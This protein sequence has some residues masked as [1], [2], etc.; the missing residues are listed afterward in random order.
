LTN[1]TCE[2]SGNILLTVTGGTAP[3]RYLWS[4]GDTTNSPAILV[5]DFYDV[6]ITDD[7]GC[8]TI[9]TELP[10]N[11]ECN[12]CIPPV[13]ESVII[14]DAT[15]DNA[16][17]SILIT[18]EGSGYLFNWNPV[19]VNNVISNLA[20]GEVYVTITDINDPTC[21][22]TETFVIGNAD[23]PQGVTVAT[24]DAT[25]EDND[26]IAT[27]APATY[28]YAWEN[29]DTTNT[30]NN[31]L[32]DTTYVV[33]VIDP[34][35]N[36]VDIITVEVGSTNPISATEVINT[37]PNCDAADGSV[38]I[39]PTG[40]SGN[41]EYGTWP[42]DTRTDLPSG[43]HSVIVRDLET[44]CVLTVEF[45]LPDNTQTANINI[46]NNNID[47]NC[48]DD[49]D[50][51]VAFEIVY[52]A[53]FA[54]PADTVIV[55][56][57]TNIS[58][59]NGML[60]A[61]DYCIVIYDANDCMAATECFVI[62][63]PTAL[64]LDAVL[65]NTSCETNSAIDLIIQG[66]TTPYKIDWSDTINP[67]DSEDRTDLPADNYSVTV[68]DANNCVA[69]LSDL[70]I[71]DNCPPCEET[72]I[73]VDNLTLV[74]ATYCGTQDGSAVIDVQGNESDYI[75]TWFPNVSNVYRYDYK[76]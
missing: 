18:M 6:T 25:C 12:E 40:G 75:Y 72:P 50:G 46:A 16:D 9:L 61:G 69:I 31:L 4:N 45:I 47:L 70:I 41:Y 57:G 13:I 1:I 17:G 51:T 26:G 11:D 62:N 63:E 14:T 56:D 64:L 74:D 33:T 21:F 58:A 19:N 36:C 52:D 8:E 30:R 73:V 34:S 23:G 59:I 20:A 76:S 7:N 44:G 65:V 22:I 42:G 10:I 5:P 67:E 2:E 66:G 49:T 28:Q 37:L 32:A 39:V 15:C 71:I 29:G 60:S 68:T 48:A 55:R 35:T 27:L 38:T 3:Y 53:G 43:P 54:L 24:T